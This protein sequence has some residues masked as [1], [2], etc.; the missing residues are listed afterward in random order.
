[1][2]L[3]K[4]SHPTLIIKKQ[5]LW[6]THGQPLLLKKL[7]SRPHSKSHPVATGAARQLTRHAGTTKPLTSNSY[8]CIA[9]V[10]YPTSENE[11]S[12]MLWS[13]DV[14]DAPHFSAS[15]H[16]QG[17]NPLNALTGTLELTAL[18]AF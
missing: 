18:E 1:L 16:I 7:I 4:I 2:C 17:P 3:A 14:A 11:A 13:S 15:A 10:F 9:V 8:Y 6:R 5:D 12:A